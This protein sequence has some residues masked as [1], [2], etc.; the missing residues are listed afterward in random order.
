MSKMI[1]EN[2]NL[3]QSESVVSPNQSEEDAQS[4]YA[5]APDDREERRAFQLANLKT[6]RDNEPPNETP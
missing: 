1:T 5:D 3:S 6:W 4:F 2:E